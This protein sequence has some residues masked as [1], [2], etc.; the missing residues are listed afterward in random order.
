MEATEQVLLLPKAV[1]NASMEY[2]AQLLRSLPIDPNRMLIAPM[3]AVCLPR[4]TGMVV[5]ASG[6]VPLQATCVHSLVA[7]IGRSHIDELAGGHKLISK[8]C[9]HVPFEPPTK[10]DERAPEHAYKRVLGDIASYCTKDNVQDYT[11]TGRK[12]KEAVYA[13]IAISNV[14]DNPG[15]CTRL[16]Y[17]VDKVDRQAEGDIPTIRALLHKLMQIFTVGP[18]KEKL[19]STPDW[20]KDQTPYNAKKSKRLSMSPT[21]ADLPSPLPSVFGA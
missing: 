15:D 4:H 18:G 1:P 16:T 10:K 9:W 6:P 17:M 19:N 2:V 5:N 21:D 3:S 11:L 12:P 14:H 13:V 20:S 7:H 8:D